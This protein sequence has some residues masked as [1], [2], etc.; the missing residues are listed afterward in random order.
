MSIRED[1]KHDCIVSG[2][3]YCG[4]NNKYGVYIIICDIC[5][6]YLGTVNLWYPRDVEFTRKLKARRYPRGRDSK[7]TEDIQNRFS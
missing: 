7:F 2:Y 3:I 1:P 6:R 4:E 5:Q